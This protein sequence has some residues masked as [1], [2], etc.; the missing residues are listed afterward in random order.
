MSEPEQTVP[1][2]DKD[3]IIAAMIAAGRSRASVAKAVGL[4]PRGLHK[5]L[6]RP[7]L[8]AKVAE[9]RREVLD[10]LLG[11]LLGAG[12]SAVER[13]HGVILDDSAAARD[14]IAA[15]VAL[16]SLLPKLSTYF[17]L[18]ARVAQLEAERAE[19]AGAGG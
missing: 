4:S 15:S 17:D 19:Y 12:P 16:L 7:G 3:D 1:P 2:A 5:R 10:G 11:K 8:K 18:E 9:L 14:R 6:Q 13:L